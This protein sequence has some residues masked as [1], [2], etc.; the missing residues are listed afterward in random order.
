M[1]ESGRVPILA[2]IFGMYELFDSDSTAA[3][4]ERVFDLLT[5]ARAKRGVAEPH[6]LIEI[7][8]ETVSAADDIG[9]G[10]H[11]QLALDDLAATASARLRSAVLTWYFE[12]SDLATIEFPSELLSARRLGAAIGVAHRKGPK[13]AWGH[14]VVMGVSRS[15]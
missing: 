15:Y 10:M 4:A 6:R 1:T 5:A 8:D 7:L 11:A 2:G 3:D 14:Y 13:D 12:T 9:R